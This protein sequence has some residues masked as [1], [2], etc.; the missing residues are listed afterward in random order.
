MQASTVKQALKIGAK[1]AQAG[2]EAERLRESV[3]NAVEDTVK[4]TRR[5][6]KQGQHAVEDLVDEATYAVKRHPLPS[7]GLTLGIGFALGTMFGLVL[8]RFKVTQRCSASQGT[9]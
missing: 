9:Q 8:S 3:T 5:A 4:S 6:I 1:V 2:M 7:V